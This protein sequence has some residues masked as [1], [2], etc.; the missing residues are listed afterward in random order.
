MNDDLMAGRY[1]MSHSKF[2]F[3]LFRLVSGVW[4]TIPALLFIAAVVMAVFFDLAYAIVAMMILLI[5]VPLLMAFLYIYYGFAQG[6]WINILEK[7]IKLISEGIEVKMFFKIK[8]DECETEEGLQDNSEC[9][10]VDDKVE[11]EERVRI[12][13]WSEIKDLRLS[14]DS[15]MLMLADRPM[16]FLYIPLTTMKKESAFL[17]MLKK[18]IASKNN[19]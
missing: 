6:C 8:K 11:I 13:K 14:T 1:R 18:N 16:G 10:D 9:D 19:A 12:I 4:L 17:E 15:V 7:E 5:L 2:I 3:T